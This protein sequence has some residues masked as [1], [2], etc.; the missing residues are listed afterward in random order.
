MDLN[1]LFQI[2]FW[3]SILVFTPLCPFLGI[4][5]AIW[6]L[7]GITPQWVFNFSFNFASI[8]SLTSELFTLVTFALL[9]CFLPLAFESSELF[10]K[11]G[12]YHR[13]SNF[14]SPFGETLAKKF[15]KVYLLNLKLSLLIFLVIFFFIATI[16]QFKETLTSTDLFNLIITAVAI[17]PAFLLSLRL[18]ANP[19]RIIPK[20]QGLLRFL[21]WVFPVHYLA[22]PNENSQTIRT[23]KERFVSLYF[24]MIAT[25]LFT[26]I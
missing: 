5:A 22:R 24:S 6:S 1:I 12:V 13:L 19:V 18:L 25:V 7:I 14:E 21:N 15:L 3:L 26:L 2:F 20:F 8:V 4:S 17:C 10:S 9:I 11:L 23:I 16:I